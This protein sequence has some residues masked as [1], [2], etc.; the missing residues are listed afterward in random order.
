MNLGQKAFTLTALM[1]CNV[2]HA[3]ESTNYFAIGIGANAPFTFG[4]TPTLSVYYGRNLIKFNDWASLSGEFNASFLFNQL[5]YNMT[6]PTDN[7]MA[8]S[9][10]PMY[11]FTI[12]NNLSL[13]IGIWLGYL[14]NGYVYAEKNMVPQNSNLN[15]SDNIGITYKFSNNIITIIRISHLSNAN[16]AMPNPGLSLIHWN[17]G[18][19]Y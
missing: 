1:V 4:Y 7:N 8:I 10:V 16:I 14:V 2:I 9:L 6:N 12:T 19:S 11:N 13:N 18:Y 5:T 17:I 15:F 3:A